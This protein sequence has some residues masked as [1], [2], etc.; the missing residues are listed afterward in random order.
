MNEE[1]CYLDATELSAAIRDKI[2]SSQEVV[3]AFLQRIE[4][5]NPIINALIAF[6]ND[7]L[8]NA[9][10]AD[11]ALGRGDV[12]GPLHG[13]P[14]TVKDCI[15]TRGIVTTRG[16]RLFAN[17]VPDHDATVVERI[18]GA[19]GIL[20]GK[21][22]MPEF[23]LWWETDNLVYGRT[24]NPW[25]IER[26][27]GGSSGGEAAAI[28]SGMSPLGIGSDVGGSVREPANY[29]G[30]VGLKA[31]HGRIPLTGHWPETLLRFM[32]VGP[33]ATTIRDIGL[34]FNLMAGPD[35]LDSYAV[36]YPIDDGADLSLDPVGLKI[37]WCPEGPFGPIDREV[38]STVSEAARALQ[39]IGANVEEV[40]LSSWS[41][42][43]PQ[44]ISSAIFGVEGGHYLAPLIAGKQG[45]LSPI[46]Q[47]RL[48]QPECSLTEYLDAL[49]ELD[50][51][52]QQVV[53]YFKS[54][55]C[56]IC[57][58][59]PVAAHPHNS[60]GLDV[61][62]EHVLGRHALNCTV[63]FDLTGSPALSVPF[64]WTQDGLPIGVQLVGRHFDEVNLLK[65]GSALELNRGSRRYRP[66]DL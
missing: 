63:P 38:Q 34:S 41:G 64:G 54:F 57:P 6:P 59:G 23:A 25:N 10:D 20:I 55:D 36:P 21:S 24:N 62:D 19:G 22:N 16:S 13:V 39:E 5:V 44:Q 45:D 15:D 28:V 35:G 12:W 3:Q 56:L 8:Q 40:S 52:R 49:N 27:P 32:H 47:R 29:C 50:G 48:R 42:F 58:T 65:V 9:R 11:I 30:T 26:T 7:V 37:G 14:F 66:H 43:S 31:T 51:F 18:K 33:L 61:G 4:Q 2:F 46:M 53:Q 1:I 60:R 17:R